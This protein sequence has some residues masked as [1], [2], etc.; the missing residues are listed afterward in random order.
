MHVQDLVR[1]RKK[2]ILGFVHTGPDQKILLTHCNKV[3]PER[4]GGFDQWRERERDRFVAKKEPVPGFG[5][6]WG[7]LRLGSKVEVGKFAFNHR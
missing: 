5:G 7:S 6:V 2:G 1:F 4:T 3:D